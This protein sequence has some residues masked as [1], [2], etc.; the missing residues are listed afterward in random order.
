VV[1]R[2][3]DESASRPGIELLLSKGDENRMGAARNSVPKWVDPDLPWD[4][5]DEPV[6]VEEPALKA[7]VDR[8]HNH[9]EM[10]PEAMAMAIAELQ[11]TM[12]SLDGRLANAQGDVADAAHATKGLGA[13]MVQMGDALSRRVRS[14]E[15]AAEAEAER[16]AEKARAEAAAAP[17][18][19]PRGQILRLSLG[20]AGALVAIV[21]AVML[22][23]PQATTRPRPAP[24]AQAAPTQ[25][26]PTTQAAPPTQ[27]APA[28]QATPP[29]Q[30][31]PPPQ[32][33]YSPDAPAP[34]ARN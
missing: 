12:K 18:P 30:A 23:L 11:E 1:C 28:A 6:T 20:L 25:A 2:A 4:D 9:E 32:V 26:A 17:N 34:G 19:P 13:S 3:L 8:F 15:E 7:V 10:S 5:I 27:A 29:N 22:L 21:A 14:L 24:T 33:L 31:A 16:A